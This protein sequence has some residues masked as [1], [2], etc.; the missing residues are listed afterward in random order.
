MSYT[1]SNPNAALDALSDALSRKGATANTFSGQN[2]AQASAQR[3]A[4]AH[5]Q[6]PAYWLETPPAQPAS[7]LHATPSSLPAMKTLN[8]HFSAM[9][10]QPETADNYAQTLQASG[11]DHA[12]GL[13]VLD[14]SNARSSID[15]L[16][17]LE[18]L[19]ATLPLGIQEGEHYC[20][21][22]LG[23]L[24]LTQA[25][26]RR[27]KAMIEAAGV[28]IAFA[29]ILVPQTQLAA[30]A[31]GFSVRDALP[32]SKT[33]QAFL[34]VPAQPEP[35]FIA[36]SIDLN[37][38]SHEALHQVL[39]EEIKYES[40]AAE[41]NLQLF[42]ALAQELTQPE[43]KAE[44]NDE[45]ELHAPEMPTMAAAKNEA[46]KATPLPPTLPTQVVDHTLRSGS[47]IV[48]PGHLIVMG[49]VHAGSEV[50]AA[51]D[52]LVWGEL[53]GIAHAGAPVDENAA[54]R[55]ATIRVLKLEAIQLR[56]GDLMARRPDR[57]HLM[58]QD[59]QHHQAMGAWHPEMA[60]VRGN[61]IKIW[62][63]NTASMP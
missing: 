29:L 62:A 6:S 5:R 40:P 22:D 32:D 21:L 33:M 55:A 50:I 60:C 23:T 53:R 26:I 11:F 31:E 8:Y 56:I 15:A 10:S 38:T 43:P 4:T 41:N 13:P 27:M 37:E 9:P 3:S 7:D 12:Q 30:I 28:P 19:L 49:D 25:V 16:N 2:A 48:S 18:F 51:G 24:M 63:Q 52:I 57:R 35:E 54:T 20:I 34:P 36:Q 61:E 47:R 1:P 44:A 14:L 46:L 17:R 42:D 58:T 45:P 59:R 39:P